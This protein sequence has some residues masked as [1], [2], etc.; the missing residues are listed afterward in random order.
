MVG[1]GPDGSAIGALSCGL[2]AAVV[3]GAL[4]PGCVAAV[5]RFYLSRHLGPATFGMYR[6][7]DAQTTAWFILLT[8]G[9]ETYIQKEIPVRPEQRAVA[10]RH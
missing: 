5:V 1:G 9:V 6:A 4:G 8:F 10:A 3:A 7:A 2:G